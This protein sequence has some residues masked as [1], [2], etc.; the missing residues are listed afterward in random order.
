MEIRERLI[1][2]IFTAVFLGFIS[3]EEAAARF[4]H[5]VKSRFLYPVRGNFSDMIFSGNGVCC[6][7]TLPNGGGEC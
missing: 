5:P 1:K 3:A 4:P 2:A 6:I 7:K